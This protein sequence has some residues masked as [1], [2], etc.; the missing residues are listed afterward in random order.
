[1][2]SK[3]EGGELQTVGL[4][5]LILLAFFPPMRNQSRGIYAESDAGIRWSK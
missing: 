5:N 3:G 2:L 1:M 4:S